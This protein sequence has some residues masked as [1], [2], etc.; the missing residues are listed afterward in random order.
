MLKIIDKDDLKEVIEFTWG[1]CQSTR[2]TCYPLR[3]SKVDLEEALLHSIQ[4]PDDKVLGYFKSNKL[5]GTVDLFV[6]RSQ[7]YLQ[8]K[9]YISDDFEAVMNELI[10]YL[11]DNYTA[12]KVHFGYPKE[13]LC[14]MNYFKTHHYKS[15]FLSR[16]KITFT[17]KQLKK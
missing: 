14:A 7:K 1:L 8:A 12:F 5:I 11:R 6:E 10:A 13:N 2:T 3:K 4:H 17:M 9:T 16:N 15:S